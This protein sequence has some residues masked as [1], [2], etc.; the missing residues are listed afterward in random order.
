MKKV[1]IQSD[2]KAPFYKDFFL[3]DRNL[4]GRHQIPEIHQKQNIEDLNK[5][6]DQL[7]LENDNFES[8]KKRLSRILEIQKQK[9]EQ[10]ED[11][12]F[13]NIDPQFQR[14]KNLILNLKQ[15]PFD[16]KLKEEM[17]I[18]PWQRVPGLKLTLINLIND[19]DVQSLQVKYVLRN[20]ETAIKDAQN[21]ELKGQT[22]VLTQ[23]PNMLIYQKFQ[24]P[25][26]LK[27]I[28]DDYK[29]LNVLFQIESEGHLLAWG[30]SN[31]TDLD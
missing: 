24:I 2:Q 25:V 29:Q 28:S 22:S 30:C 12:K 13:Q 5:K 1:E 19:F 27:K 14:E 17:D 9:L 4:P 31:L 8:E 6:I 18:S 16:L 11:T 15:N 7:Q 3:K 10:L 20:K 26:D 23:D 21:Q